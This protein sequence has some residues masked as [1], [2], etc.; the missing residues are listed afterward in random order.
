LNAAAAATSLDTRI[1]L[2]MSKTP[3][4]MKWN[5]SGFGQR[6]DR[7]ESTCLPIN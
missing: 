2:S 7:A 5:C 1:S 4:L 3:L 6:G